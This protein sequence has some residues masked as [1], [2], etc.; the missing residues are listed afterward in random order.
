MQIVSRDKEYTYDVF[1]DDFVRLMREYSYLESG[2]AGYSVLGKR[3]PFIRFGCG[4][5]KIIITGAHHGKEWITAMLNMALAEALCRMYNDNK[6][7][8][9]IDMVEY[10]YAHSIYFIPM[11]NPDGINLC[12]RGL[13][14]DIPIFTQ[15]RLIGMNSGNRD[16]IGQ[17]QSNIR[18]IDLNHNYDAMFEKGRSMEL[19]SGIYGP[20]KGRYSG[21]YP[22]SEPETQAVVS[23]TKDINP[24]I[25]IAYHSQGEEIYYSFNG[26]CARDALSIA[27]DL[28][29]AAGYRL[30]EAEGL[31]D[32]SGYKDW[33]IEQFDIPAFT[34]EV[35][36]GENPLPLSQFDKIFSDNLKAILRL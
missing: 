21:E 3:I 13:T 7:F 36:K 30:A 16:F 4:C 19:A 35:G 1:M 32:C 2:T 24:D 33:V 23:V 28:A 29:H 12:I 18:G 14:D 8:E 20:G 5:K 27:Q 26:K 9:E 25:V 6:R 31:T 17:W 10:F 22:E 34:I 15:S 11:V